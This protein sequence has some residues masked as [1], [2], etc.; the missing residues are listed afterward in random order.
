MSARQPEPTDIFYDRP[1][2]WTQGITYDE[3]EIR[4]VTHILVHFRQREPH[5]NG[6]R[7]I[8]R[9]CL[10]AIHRWRRGEGRFTIEAEYPVKT[11]GWGDVA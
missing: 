11:G 6:E 8:A 9:E 5:G 4:L 7:H 1:R 3:N 2:T 10:T